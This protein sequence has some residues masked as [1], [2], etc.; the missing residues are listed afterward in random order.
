MFATTEQS[1]EQIGFHGEK[2]QIETITLNMFYSYY[3]IRVF[4][5]DFILVFLCKFISAKAED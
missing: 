2:L 3:V 1:K 4:L 5:I